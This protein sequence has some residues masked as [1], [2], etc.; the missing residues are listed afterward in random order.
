MNVITMVDVS[1]PELIEVVVAI[2][3]T[4]WREYYT[5]IIGRLQVEYMLER[6]Q[7]RPAVAGQIKEGCRYYIIRDA[8]N[9]DI[10]YCAAVPKK[11]ELFLSKL[12]VIAEKRGQGYGK[13]AITFV[14]T[15]ARDLGMPRV[16]LTV[17]KNN[18]ASIKAYQR[19][20]FVIVCPIKQDIGNGFVMDDYVM[21]KLVTG[22]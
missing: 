22:A 8:E 11:N 9:K 12:Y 10:G 2:A 18:H 4:T 15:M 14:E 16:T 6:F 21:E 5:P 13:S 7:S 3:R 19:F 17:N 20:G 1:T